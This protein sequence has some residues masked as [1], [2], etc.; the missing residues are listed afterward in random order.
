MERFRLRDC[1][2]EGDAF[3]VH[4]AFVTPRHLVQ[5]HTHD[6]VEIWWVD[7]G[8]GHHLVNGASVPVH[9][10]DLVF[11]RVEDKH[12]FSH[13]DFAITNIYFSCD[14]LAHLRA[15][16]FADD[17]G[18]W[19]GAAPLPS[20]HRLPAAQLHILRQEAE[21]LAQ[22]QK[23]LLQIERFLLNLLA[24]LSALVPSTLPPGLPAWLQH[25]CRQI[26]EPDYLH[27]GTPAFIALTGKSPEHVARGA[28][29]A[30]HHPASARHR[31]PHDLRRHAAGDDPPTHHRHRVRL[32]LRQPFPLLPCLQRHVRHYPARLPAVHGTEVKLEVGAHGCTCNYAF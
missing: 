22:G 31:G 3:G 21:S 1:L 11:M 29:L 19:G 6:F 30:A 10:G 4:R 20:V 24:M 2:R 32:R 13:G 27:R 28:A 16:Y 25:A 26:R 5:P 14:I 9:S 8:S 23:T 7:T 17:N 15:R 12:G 18:F